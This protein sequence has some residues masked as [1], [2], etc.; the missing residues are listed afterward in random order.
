M[1]VEEVMDPATAVQN[2]RLEEFQEEEMY[3]Q[4]ELIS[5]TF[6][7]LMGLLTV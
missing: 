4:L 7:R 1:E 6:I 3:I 2:N 5:P